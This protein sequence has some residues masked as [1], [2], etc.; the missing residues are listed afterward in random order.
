ML[1]AVVMPTYNLWARRLMRKPRFMIMSMLWVV[2]RR[3]AVA[4][5]LGLAGS[6]HYRVHVLQCVLIANAQH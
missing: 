2:L 3:K 6:A 1:R 5:S 4:Q